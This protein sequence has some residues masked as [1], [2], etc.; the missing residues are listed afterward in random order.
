M[1]MDQKV[2]GEYLGVIIGE[3]RVGI[4]TEFVQ[5]VFE[6]TLITRLP[7]SPDFF[8]GMVNVRGNII[9][10]LDLLTIRDPMVPIKKIVVLKTA[11]GIV[12]LLISRLID[13]MKFPSLEKSSDIPQQLIQ[14]G[15]FFPVSA[16]VEETFNIMDVNNLIAAT[17]TQTIRQA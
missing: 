14:W 5:E 17:L 6:T 15:A 7:G 11:E 4:A 12:G 1:A 13:L 8:L 10:V 9:P 16:G 3:V 2:S